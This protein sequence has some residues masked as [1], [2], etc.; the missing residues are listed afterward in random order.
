MPLNVNKNLKKYYSISEVAD[1]FDVA[2]SLLR[3]WEK[4]FPTLAPR[5][6]RAGKRIYTEEDIER[7]RTVY[8]LVKVRGLK[9]AAARK[10]LN[11][12]GNKATDTAHMLD[13]LQD[14]RAQLVEVR[15]ALFEE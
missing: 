6:D 8:S 14:I 3:F 10:I 11:T 4:E 1:Q 13:L 9:L 15:D 7:I 2:E 12:K 5:K